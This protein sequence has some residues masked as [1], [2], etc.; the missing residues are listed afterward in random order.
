MFWQGFYRV[1]SM[2][3]RGLYKAAIAFHK[4]CTR[5]L[6]NFMPCADRG[7]GSSREARQFGRVI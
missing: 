4:A 7:A 3:S 1:F 2:I 6:P 5:L